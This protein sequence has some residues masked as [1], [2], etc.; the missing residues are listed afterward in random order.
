MPL[1]LGDRMDAL[2]VKLQT[3]IAKAEE[4]RAYA[5]ACERTAALN[6]QEN[7][8][9]KARLAEA[10]AL[11]VEWDDTFGQQNA[12]CGGELHGKTLAFLSRAPEPAA[13]P[14][15]VI[16]QREI[17]AATDLGERLQAAMNDADE[18]GY[19]T[20][21]LRSLEEHG[22]AVTVGAP[23]PT[24]A[25]LKA[26]E[27]KLAAAREIVG[28]DGDDQSDDARVIRIRDLL[29]APGPAGKE[30]GNG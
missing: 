12:M 1:G 9:L 21:M 13:E 29:R 4:L 17:D 19:W 20:D 23:F 6:Q 22:L 8:E 15:A 30:G 24:V 3:A 18:W 27:A 28:H 11:L 2:A 25:T 16:R 7:V 14:Q 10:T 26:A 5:T